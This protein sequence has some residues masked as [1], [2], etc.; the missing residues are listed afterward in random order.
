MKRVTLDNKMYNLISEE[1]YLSNTRYYNDEQNVAIEY[2]G[3]ALPL[4]IK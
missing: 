3:M 4:W 2:N 1:E